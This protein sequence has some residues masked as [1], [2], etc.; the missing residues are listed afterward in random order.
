VGNAFGADANHE[1]CR[2]DAYNQQSQRAQLEQQAIELLVRMR[3]FVC[4]VTIRIRRTQAIKPMK[5]AE[6]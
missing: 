1:D 4:A 5:P 2:G 6:C 3:L